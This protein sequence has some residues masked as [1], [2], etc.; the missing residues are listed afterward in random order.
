VERIA[1]D[2]AERIRRAIAINLVIAWRIM[3][4]TLLGRETPELPPKF[5]SPILNSMFCAHTQKK[6]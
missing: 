4:M 5:C 6:R 2:T 3:L 1:H